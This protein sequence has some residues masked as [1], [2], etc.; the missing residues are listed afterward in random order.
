MIQAVAKILK[1]LNSETDPSQISLALGFGAFAGF[2]PFVSLHNLVIILLVLILRVNLSTFLLALA[3]FSGLAYLL[4]PLFH[5][6][7]LALLTADSLQ[8]LWTTLYNSSFWKLTRFNNSILMGSFV[9]SLV[10]FFPLYFLA[11]W[12]VRQYRAQ[13]LGW[14]RKSRIMQAFTA[15]KFYSIYQ[16]ASAWWR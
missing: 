13:V 2:T 7:G 16:S 8:G 9:F 10:L 3:V 12:A 5:L 14:V 11:Q 6:L 4:D 15:S 1:V